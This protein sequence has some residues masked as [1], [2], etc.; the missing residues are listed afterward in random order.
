MGVVA[1][2]VVWSASSEG[3]CGDLVDEDIV[4]CSCCM[5]VA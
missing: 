5:C 1:L 4:V 3:G 2:R